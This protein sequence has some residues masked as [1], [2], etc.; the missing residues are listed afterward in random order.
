MSTRNYPQGR[1]VR[2]LCH[3]I[4]PSLSGGGSSV[5]SCRKIYLVNHAFFTTLV[6]ISEDSSKKNTPGK[7]HSLSFVSL[8]SGFILNTLDQ[9]TRPG[10]IV[11]ATGLKFLSSLKFQW[12]VA[13]LEAQKIVHLFWKLLVGNEAD[14]AMHFHFDLLCAN[15]QWR[16]PLISISIS[17]GFTWRGGLVGNPV[18]GRF[19]AELSRCKV[20]NKHVFRGPPLWQQIDVKWLETMSE[21]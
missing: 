9:I 8:L 16:T 7:L 12:F 14:K 10:C 11:Q 6:R 20:R 18:S 15:Q 21:F 3:V 2:N 13:I 17:Q 4:R 19:A 1:L 5:D